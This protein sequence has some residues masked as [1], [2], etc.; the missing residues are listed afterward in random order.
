M[1][2]RALSA[3]EA[4]ARIREGALSPVALIDE[5]LAHID[6]LEPSIGAWVF[7]DREGGRAAARECEA[8]ARSGRFRGP[9]HGVPVALKDIFHVAGMPTTAGAAA[10][11]HER[12]TEDA[13]SVARLRR[14][15]AI[16]LGKTTTTEFAYADPTGTRNPWNLDHTPGG[17]SSGSAAAVSARMLPLSLG[18]QTGGSTLRPAAYCGIV[19]LKPT[20][21]RISCRGVVPLAWSLDH[22]GVFSRTV[23]DAALAL[24]VLAG[25]DAADPFSAREP[26]DRYVDAVLESQRP[27]RLGLVR[28]YFLDDA[29][30]E[31]ATHLATVA[32]ILERSG[33]IIDEIEPPE[34]VRAIPSAGQITMQVE[35][36]TYH[37]D[38]FSTRASEY[39]PRLHAL[40]EAGLRTPATE[41]VAAQ[42]CRQRFRH[43][44]RALL[45]RVDALLLPVTKTPAPAGL[46]STGDPALCAP[47]SSAGFPAISIPSGLSRDRLPLGIQLVSRSFGESRLLAAAA[48]CEAVLDF[49]EAPP[50]A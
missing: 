9:L 42:R 16:I 35:A 31:I 30:D 4:A 40:V 1:S 21:G 25:Y 10:S 14:A 48:W 47:W 22:V 45:E 12:P 41:Y 18:S 13:E 6:A 15:G 5:L 20:H 32:G 3:S 29:T 2:L 26:A 27:P 39:G 44:M 50:G 17:S 46:D 11:A 49:S 24:E 36:A 37:A 19:G 7:I 28:R 8:E 23:A 34:S 33:A 38:R 43:D